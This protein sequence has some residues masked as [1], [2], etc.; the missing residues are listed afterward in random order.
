MVNR[1]GSKTMKK[2]VGVFLL[3]V[4]WVLLGQIQ[5]GDPDPGL[6]PEPTMHTL[7]EIYL[8]LDGLVPGAIGV[9]RTGLT[10]CWDEGG[11][12]TD[13]ADTG[14]DGEYQAGVAVTPR[15]TDNDDGTVRD[16][17][18]GLIWLKNANCFNTRTWTDGMSDANLLADGDCGLTDGSVA[19]DWRVPNLKELMSLLDYSQVDLMLPAGH[20]FTAVEPDDYWTST[21]IATS[22]K[23]SAWYVELDLGKSFNDLKDGLN[24]VW[25][26]RSAN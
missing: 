16:N 21:T 6:P 2:T 10:Q 14:Q 23:N 22:V 17:L 19:G 18:T 24:Y 9:G 1:K 26:V 20:P 13:C 15:F 3:A 12:L 8:K 25:P 5:A 11:T 7:E 4:V